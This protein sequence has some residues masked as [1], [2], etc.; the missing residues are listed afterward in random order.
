MNDDIFPYERKCRKCGKAIFPNPSWAYQKNGKYFCTW[1]CYREY[2]REMPKR[3]V[4]LPKVGDTIEII[5]VS[6]IP[7][8]TGKRGV[9]QFYDS[10]G[11]LH[12][13]W[14]SLVIVPGEDRYR[15]IEESK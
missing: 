2:E 4:L 1:K 8:L 12:G 10:M 3:K 6:G 13:T 14:D 5:Y 7:S 9:V 11:Q 15:I